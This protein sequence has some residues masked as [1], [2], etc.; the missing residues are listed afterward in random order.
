[1]QIN[2]INQAGNIQKAAAMAVRKPPVEMQAPQVKQ[3]QVIISDKARD[4]ASKLVGKGA[5]EE[6]NESLAVKAQETAE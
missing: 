6:A 5:Q 1:M 2:S 4:L 3:D